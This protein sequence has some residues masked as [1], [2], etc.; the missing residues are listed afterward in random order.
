MKLL[1]RTAPSGSEVN[2]RQPVA[3]D[4]LSFKLSVADFCHT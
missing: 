1:A 3:L 4:N 2:Q